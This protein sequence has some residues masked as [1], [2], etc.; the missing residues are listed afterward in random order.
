MDV[1]IA[2]KARA[3]IDDIL[4]WTQENLGPLTLRRYAKLLATA[5]E[6]VAANP[7]LAGSCQR[8]EI[9][10]HCRT[11]HLF[12]SRKTAARAGD[13]I[14]R[15]RHLLLYRVT[16]AGIVEFGRVLHDSMDLTSH[17]PEEYQRSEPDG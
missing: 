1:I 13:R 6:E 7:E 3:D 12:F 2:P 8:P 5:I 15:P 14:R 4:T 9:A 16:E 11:Y 17:L 10:D